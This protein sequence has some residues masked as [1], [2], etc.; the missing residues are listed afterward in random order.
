MTY[1][2]VNQTGSIIAKYNLLD[3]AIKECLFYQWENPW[4]T[5]TITIT[6]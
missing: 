1:T 3:T 6:N 2:L 4:E 5:I